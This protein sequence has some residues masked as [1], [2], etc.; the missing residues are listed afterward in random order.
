VDIYYHSYSGS[1]EASLKALKKVYDWALGRELYN[2]H[3]SEYTAK[4]LD[5]N[6]MALA[7]SGEAWLIRGGGSLRELRVP[8]SMGYPDLARSEG[9][10][11]YADAGEARYIHMS[12]ANCKLVLSSKPPERPYLAGANAALSDWAA[13]G[14]HLSMT[15]EGHLDLVFSLGDAGHC[16]VKADG[17]PVSGIAGPG[18]RQTFRIAAR[19]ARIQAD[20]P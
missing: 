12:G 17:S 8:T 16:R 20:C 7:R 6:G 14:R 13:D 19:K 15:L 5:F 9:V 11:G 3:V 4:V 2:V 1:K 18:D 10:I